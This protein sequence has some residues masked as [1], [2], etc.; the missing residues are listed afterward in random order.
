MKLDRDFKGFKNI[1]LP[2]CNNLY[3][4][5]ECIVPSIDNI[6][7]GI[8]TCAFAYG[9]TGSGKTHTIFG[10]NDELGMYRLFIREICLRVQKLKN[11]TIIEVRFIELYQNIVR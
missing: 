5:N 11:D 7:D 3:T 9:H 6:F 10:Y 2:N 8:S 1:V 4:F